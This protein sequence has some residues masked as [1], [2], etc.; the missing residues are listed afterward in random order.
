MELS[1]GVLSL[2]L[3][4]IEI[5]LT[6]LDEW[7]Y[8]KIAHGLKIINKIQ[9]IEKRFKIFYDE[10]EAISFKIKSNLKRNILEV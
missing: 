9:D 2:N 5:N 3:G 10:V 1:C 7:G 6:L 8:H 4:K